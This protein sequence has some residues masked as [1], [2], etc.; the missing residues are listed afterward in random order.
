MLI[1]SSSKFGASIPPNR[2]SSLR[3]SSI[4]LLNKLGIWPIQHS[5]MVKEIK[6]WDQGGILDFKNKDSLSVIVKNMDLL[7]AC[8]NA[9]KTCPNNN[10][11]EIMDSTTV[12]GISYQENGNPILIT[13]NNGREMVDCELLVIEIINEIGAD[14]PMSK[15]RQFANIE[16][17]GLDHDQMGVVATCKVKEHDNHTVYNE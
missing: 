15:I 5:Q 9:L 2:I 11:L 7:S 6:V 17:H 14:G 10:N 12:E 4:N 16:S 3:P 13:N 1:E 8:A